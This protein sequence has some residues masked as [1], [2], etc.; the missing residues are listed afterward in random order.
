MVGTI[1]TWLG[2]ALRGIWGRRGVT[3]TILAV[4]VVATAAATVGPVYFNAAGTSI[5]QDTVRSAPAS[6]QVIDVVRQ[7]DLDVNQDDQL[8]TD[9]KTVTSASPSA[10]AF[11]KPVQA[12]EF[13]GHIPAEPP[14]FQTLLSWRDGAC[15]QLTIVAGA[16]PS[17]A[18]QVIASNALK[19]QLGLRLGQQLDDGLRTGSGAAIPLTI[20]GFYDVPNP[21][22]AYWAA[23]PYFVAVAGSGNDISKGPV[24]TDGLF[25]VRSTFA[26]AAPYSQ[27]LDVVD[28]P[29]NA[30]TLTYQARAGIEALAGEV[31]AH[32]DSAQ[33]TTTI[34][35]VLD[36]AATSQ[37]ALAVPVFLVTLQLLVLCWLLLFL[38]VTDA[39]EARGN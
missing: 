35:S 22:G 26:D 33:V 37:Q 32:V 7:T 17:Q 1:R 19:R 4:A 11:G 39:V 34:P 24:Y 28:L 15:A 29:L 21:F 10:N 31:T 16:C 30:D 27:G 14:P 20:S 8:A 23:R 36:S 12:V 2:I 9:V 18:G 6:G 13:P 5:L 3:A 25:T 38:L